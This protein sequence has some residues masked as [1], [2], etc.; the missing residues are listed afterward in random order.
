VLRP[1][2]VH[3]DR[4]LSD[5]W[6]MHCDFKI[7]D[8]RVCYYTLVHGKLAYEVNTL[9]QLCLSSGRI[10]RLMCRSS[11]LWNFYLASSR[12]G[13][14]TQVIVL[15]TFIRIVTNGNVLDSPV[16][17]LAAPQRCFESLIRRLESGLC[18]GA[19][20]NLFNA[21]ALVRMCLHHYVWSRS[22]S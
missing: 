8:F 5:N 17:C 14:F 1:L 13:G 12:C 19:G 7:R 10:R 3:L 21:L 2:E 11:L 20:R 22:P 6:A 18:V 15:R 16:S 9:Q 4:V